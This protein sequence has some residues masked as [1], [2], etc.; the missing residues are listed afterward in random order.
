MSLMGRGR[1]WLSGRLLRLGVGRMLRG[2]EVVFDRVEIEW[3]GPC[4]D[5]E[6]SILCKL[7]PQRD[8]SVFEFCTSLCDHC[9]VQCSLCF[10]SVH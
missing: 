10:D 8:T 6:Q 2:G 9:Y 5:F 4:C 3:N 7:A 1:R